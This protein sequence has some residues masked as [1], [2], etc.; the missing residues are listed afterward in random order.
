MINT[1][2]LKT[3]SPKKPKK[4]FIII[5]IIF[6]TIILLALVGYAYYYFNMTPAAKNKNISN[7]VK[8]L[9]Q[10]L[11][12]IPDLKSKENIDKFKKLTKEI[13]AAQ[14]QQWES[15]QQIGESVK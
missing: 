6:A 14:Q 5:I 8:Q 2:P 12:E 7:K 1:I 10:Q 4:L 15:V 13:Q 11:S 3:Q 9:Q